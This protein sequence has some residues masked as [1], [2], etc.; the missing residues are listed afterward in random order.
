MPLIY[1]TWAIAGIPGIENNCVN[2]ASLRVIQPNLIN[3]Y[4]LLAVHN[5]PFAE[6]YVK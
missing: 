6:F 2:I 3:T 1:Y 5:I 4:Q